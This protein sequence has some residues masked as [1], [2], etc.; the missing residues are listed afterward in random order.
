M[1][2]TEFKAQ[3][4]REVLRTLGERLIEASKNDDDDSIEAHLQTLQEGYLDV[5]GPEDFFGTEGWEHWL[6][7]D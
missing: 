3:K 1:D 2:L 5:L 7:L 6:G 4:Q